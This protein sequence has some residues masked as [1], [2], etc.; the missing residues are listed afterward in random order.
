MGRSRLC[1][2]ILQKN[3][4]RYWGESV[5]V[6]FQDTKRKT[7]EK[8]IYLQE[9][10]GVWIWFWG[11]SRW[12]VWPAQRSGLNAKLKP[13]G[14]AHPN[15][16]LLQSVPSLN[17]P[18]P[19]TVQYDDMTTEKCLMFNFVLY[20]LFHCH[21]SHTLK[22]YFCHLNGLYGLQLPLWRGY[23]RAWDIYLT[24]AVCLI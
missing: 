22:E 24:Q 7:K 18:D 3:K 21:K 6:M 13:L 1:I 15:T 12:T 5:R 20:C 10:N 17:F 23:S 9:D 8:R 4:W 2:V 19:G 16:P 11:K 14:S